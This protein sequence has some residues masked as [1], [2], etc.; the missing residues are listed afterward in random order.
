MP[1]ITVD[2][3]INTKPVLQG[4]KEMT[5]AIRS[6]QGWVT[7]AGKSMD[8]S[9]VG[10]A[11]AMQ[12]NA[13]ASK[14]FKVQIDALE[15]SA[16]SL[17]NQMKRISETRIETK[18]YTQI[19][20]E[21]AEADKTLTHL[22]IAGE[23]DVEEINA[24]KQALAELIYEKEQLEKGN[25]A[26]VSP[27]TTEDYRKA[28]EKLREVQDKL[29]AA[30]EQGMNAIKP[31][32]IQQWE[33]MRT[34]TA[35][36]ANAL[37][38][39]LNAALLVGHALL[40]PFQTLNR[41]IPIVLSGMANL[42]AKAINVAVSFAKMV[43]S[44][45]VETVQRLGR[46]ALNAASGLARMVVTAPIAVIQRLANAAKNAAVNLAKMAG[47]AVM[48]GVKKIG[49]MA[50]NASKAI[51]GIGKSARR[52]NGGIKQ[53]ISMLIRYGLGIRSLFILVRR[54]RSAVV[55]AFKN[56]A[57]SVPEVNKA[58]SSLSASLGRLKNSLATAFQPILSAVAPY[59]TQL[60]DLLSEAMTR[61]GMFF[62]ALTG[63]N[64]VY[65]ATKANYD[66]AKSLDKTKQ[67]AK[68][69]ENQLASFDEL[70]I[71]RA[72]NDSGSGNAV[73]A[74]GGEF[75]KVPLESGIK[76]FV[77]TLKQMIKGGEFAEIGDLLAERINK[78]ISSIDWN[79][80]AVKIGNLI[81]SLT[82][83]YN[84]FMEGIDWGQIGS[85]IASA[86]NG[87]VD[88]VNFEDIGRAL[89]QRV[90]ALFKI[91]RG[92]VNDINALELGEA[93]RTALSSMVKN[94]N[95]EE[96]GE[97]LNQA[98]HKLLDVIKP[99][100]GDEETW[101]L[102]GYKLA[103][104]LNRLFGTNQSGE[105]IWTRL[106]DGVVTAAK[107]VIASLTE[108]VGTFEW[109]EHGRK[110][111]YAV[112]KLIKEFPTKELGN[113]ITIS[114]RGIMDS[115]LPTISDRTVWQ[116]AGAK[117]GD[118]LTALF[119]DE[120]MWEDIGK[121]ANSMMSG[122]L[123][124]GNGLVEKFQNGGAT[125]AANAIK[126][127][128]AEIKWKDIATQTWNLVQNA[129]SAAG[130]FID[131][132][133]SVDSMVTNTHR[134]PNALKGRAIAVTDDLQ[135]TI[136][137]TTTSDSRSLGE[138]LATS[139]KNAF[140]DIPWSDIANR[141]WSSIQ[142]GFA[143][144]GANASDFIASLLGVSGDDVERA[145]GNKI[146]AVGEKLATLISEAF[147][148]AVHLATYLIDSFDSDAFRTGLESILKNLD[149]G[150]IFK[151]LFIGLGKTS[152]KLLESIPFIGDWFKD[153]F[154]MAIVEDDI[155]G[156]MR[157][158]MGDVFDKLAEFGASKSG[159]I[160]DSLLEGLRK[161]TTEDGKIVPDIRKWLERIFDES[162]VI[163]LEKGEMTTTQFFS[164]LR[165][166]GINSRDVTQLMVAIESYFTEGAKN[167]ADA[168]VDTFITTAEQ[169]APEVQEATKST[170]PDFEYFL[171]EGNEMGGGL[172]DSVVDSYVEES[173]IR[174][175]DIQSATEGTFDDF[176]Y[177]AGYAANDAV[178]SLFSTFILQT[179][180]R[181]PDAETAVDGAFNEIWSA[182]DAEGNGELIA[183]D[184]MYSIIG[185]LDKLESE[186][187]EEFKNIVN[188]MFGS[189]DTYN[190]AKADAKDFMRGL[191]Q[192]MWD[193][194]G[195]T[196]KKLIEIVDTVLEKLR[197]SPDGFD[198]HSPSKRAAG[199]GENFMK[200]FVEGV[201]GDEEST[202][203]DTV[204]VFTNIFGGIVASAAALAL[205][206]VAVSASMDAMSSKIGTT[207]DGVST[208]FSSTWSTI[209]TN[210]LSA[211]NN[212]R[213]DISTAWTNI[214]NTVASTT[215]TLAHS[216]Q[217]AFRG[218]ANAVHNVNWW[219]IG[220]SIVAGIQRGV[221]DNW[222]WLERTVWNL[223]IRLYN[224]ACNALGIHSPS[225]LFREG[226]GQMIGLGVAEGFEDTEPTIMNSVTEVADAMANKMARTDMQFDVGAEQ[227][228]GT[229][230]DKIADSF[231]TL[232][233]RLQTIADS[234]A[235]RTPAVAAGTVVPYNIAAQA[236]GTSNGIVETLEASNDDLANVVIQ[237]TNNAA[238][239][240]V[241]AIQRYGGAGNN[242]VST[243][244]I[245]D[246]INRRA[247]AQGA[248]P[249][250]T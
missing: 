85:G 40:H 246:E 205:L 172:A 87:L 27:E 45:V 1:Q 213:N 233:D 169:R 143:T 186:N 197:S 199:Y 131:A 5:S 10:Y 191:I 183:S 98:I 97:T 232:L 38:K 250:L 167:V 166:A 115:I 6:L 58:I 144:A 77:N 31:I 117:L 52:S 70:N 30:R 95:T 147:K 19:K 126:A 122:V 128:L 75:V 235:F 51:L 4:A 230:S 2:T 190:D 237:A 13:Q 94:I 17:Q 25:K 67:S 161:M 151:A 18:E 179:L 83:F 23:K 150:S 208:K 36:V 55:D 159:L 78:F 137:R 81:N 127:A 224:T 35:A 229:F 180:L 22:L 26:F 156:K 141:L 241:E 74:D 149:Y 162:G 154:E 54:L 63:Q 249:I 109:G 20:K 204:G 187:E 185:A 189:V 198:E 244:R 136:S 174:K 16:Q 134:I 207:L 192:G 157:E 102:A 165:E 135:K 39:V 11:K 9:L 42:A 217:T 164:G 188:S 105:T 239:A 99:A 152:R 48:S 72:P 216:A 71:L 8:A 79:G 173:E 29:T 15:D 112:L 200:G 43:G 225:K 176:P 201:Q 108:F 219:N 107:S 73:A 243:N 175:P 222:R 7:K 132:L 209:R 82:E 86:I 184:W 220:D 21:I 202:K 155:V 125:Q 215:G 14:E 119:E 103:I 76:E 129:F 3:G 218:M 93:L 62:A 168:G 57:Q 178:E 66:Y 44:R 177:A 130:S 223:A 226:V 139:I 59:L 206:N 118:L 53:A 163:A 33:S 211:C 92:F 160:S 248:S 182:I 32:H 89:T 84:A 56:M 24:V 49:T 34:A 111:H 138:K 195:S 203:K 96:M 228:L 214:A 68:A 170:L 145:E 240:I 121:V 181:Q 247:R 236:A 65:K 193:S 146:K 234:V 41:I 64:Y 46:A 238:L 69:A 104:M 171:Q 47:N 148:S 123:S 80:Y 227:A 153:Q 91:L 210:T 101:R 158:A 88:T 120:K 194:S 124:F 60:M 221:Q 133:F 28:A 106:A 140:E 231:A 37:G 12:N 142:S 113:F 212:I 61:V 196:S 50:A 110:F 116:S 90:N 114:L 100:L 242:A 245:I